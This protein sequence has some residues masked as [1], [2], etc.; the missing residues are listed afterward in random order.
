MGWNGRGMLP[1]ML[2]GLKR[3]YL[4]GQWT[5]LIGGLP[6]AILSGMDVVKKICEDSLT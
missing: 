2:P 5:K 3:L 1:D 4:A 6:I